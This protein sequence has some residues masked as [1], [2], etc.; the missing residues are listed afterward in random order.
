MLPT[1]TTDYNS[2]CVLLCRLFL[3]HGWHSWV[4][5]ASGHLIWSNQQLGMN[6]S[7]YWWLYKPPRKPAR[8]D[9]SA[10]Y[11]GGQFQEVWLDICHVVIPK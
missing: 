7:D 1:N 2:H 6:S 8:T 10:C 3:S 4:L 11:D 9:S 5:V